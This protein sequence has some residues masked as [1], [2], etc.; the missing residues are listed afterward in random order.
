M[1]LVCLIIKNIVNTFTWINENQ[2]IWI[3]SYNFYYSKIYLTIFNIFKGWCYTDKMLLIKLLDSYI[4]R[5]IKSFYDQ[6]SHLAKNEIS[7]PVSSQM[8]FHTAKK[9][10][11]VKTK[12]QNL[13]GKKSHTKGNYSVYTK[14]FENLMHENYLADRKSVRRIK[15]QNAWDEMNNVFNS[16][17][18]PIIPNKISKKPKKNIKEIVSNEPYHK[19]VKS[20]QIYNT[21]LLIRNEEKL[22]ASKNKV[23]SLNNHIAFKWKQTSK[24]SKADWKKR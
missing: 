17:I 5:N 11:K 10:G 3:Y 6:R 7:I 4:F 2:I 9:K 20:D 8:H 18:A 24:Y 22:R 21:K 12:A 1:K 13:Q 23:N 19:R 14:N 15:P 16:M